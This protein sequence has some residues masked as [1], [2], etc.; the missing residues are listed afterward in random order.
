MNFIGVSD[1]ILKKSV[2]RGN[3]LIGNILFGKF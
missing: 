1:T 2:E 3:Y